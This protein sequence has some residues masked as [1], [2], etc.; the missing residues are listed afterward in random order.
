MLPNKKGVGKAVNLPPQT[1]NMPAYESG[2]ILIGNI[3]PYLKKIWHANRKGGCSADVLNIRVKEHHDSRF[4][5]YSLFRD[6]F[7]KHMM[8]GSKGT[9]MPRGDKTQIMRF[10]LPRFDKPV[11]QEIAAILSSLDAKIDLNNRIN[12]KLE[13]MAKTLY[14]YWFVQFDFPDENGKPYKS[15]GGKMEY[16]PTLK[17]DIPVGWEVKDLSKIAFIKKGVLITEDTAV[18]SGEIKVISAGIDYSYYHNE[19]NYPSNTIT[20]SA[21]GANAGFIN[22]WREPIFA[23]DCTVVRGK[24]DQET[25]IILYSLKMRQEYLYQQAR[26][27]AQPHVYPKDIEALKMEVPPSSLLNLFGEIVLKG[28]EKIAQNIKENKQLTQL[29]DWLLP[30]LMNGQV[31]IKDCK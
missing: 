4:V 16:N 15:S 19:S 30:M 9:K 27:S 24:T 11:Q 29:R 17:R 12:V 18:T 31:K 7:F 28:N 22:F 21:S 23:C 6:D 10:T 26:G 3:R 2:D 8:R 25:L 20:I 1:G 5:Y 14:D 13:A